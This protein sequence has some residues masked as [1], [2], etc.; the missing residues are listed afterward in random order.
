MKSWPVTLNVIDPRLDGMKNIIGYS[1][2]FP[3]LLLSKNHPFL[4]FS[5]SF[6]VSAFFFFLLFPLNARHSA[7]HCV[8]PERRQVRTR[9]CKRQAQHFFSPSPSL[10]LQTHTQKM[11]TLGK[12]FLPCHPPI[13]PSTHPSS[14]LIRPGFQERGP[15]TDDPVTS[16]RASPSL[17]PSHKLMLTLLTYTVK[18][19]NESRHFLLLLLPFLL[20]FFESCSCAH[21]ETKPRQLWSAWKETVTDFQSFFFFFFPGRQRSS[22]AKE[23]RIWLYCH[24]LPGKDPAPPRIPPPCQNTAPLSHWLTGKPPAPLIGCCRGSGREEVGEELKEAA[25]HS[26][27]ETRVT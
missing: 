27:G 21:W 22:P 15:E 13:A 26:Q 24:P 6:L 12:A 19:L 17:A 2:F 10:T 23:L 8:Q 4:S 3:G 25:V 20:S 16:S 7:D 5:L 14:P 18:T 11:S 1:F 9:P